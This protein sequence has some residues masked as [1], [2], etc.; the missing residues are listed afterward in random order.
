MLYFKLIDEPKWNLEIE[1]EQNLSKQLRNY[2][3][4]FKGT[5]QGY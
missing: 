4:L 3:H 2:F 5:L 1:I